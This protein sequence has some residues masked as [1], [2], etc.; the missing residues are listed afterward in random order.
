MSAALGLSQGAR[1]RSPQGEVTPV[2]A[3]PGRRKQARTAACKAK[4]LLSAPPGRPSALSTALRS[5]KV[6]L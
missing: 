2:N 6:L 3:A 1:Y 5:T 4:V